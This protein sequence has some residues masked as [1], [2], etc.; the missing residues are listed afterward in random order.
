MEKNLETKM[1]ALEGRQSIGWLDKSFRKFSYLRVCNFMEKYDEQLKDCI[2][3]P[4]NSFARHFNDKGCYQGSNGDL[5]SNDLAS[6]SKFRFIYDNRD[7]LEYSP[8]AIELEEYERSF[9]VKEQFVKDMVVDI[10][11]DVTEFFEDEKNIMLVAVLGITICICACVVC[12]NCCCRPSSLHLE[13]RE[14]DLELEDQR[15]DND[16]NAVESKRRSTNL[17]TQMVQQIRLYLKIELFKVFRLQFNQKISDT[18]SICMNH[19]EGN[20]KAILTPCK[21]IFHQQCFY[22]WANKCINNHMVRVNELR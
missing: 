20:E 4:T 5:Q 21:H 6:D 8:S 16:G 17:K 11:G 10:L 12:K 1:S 14:D 13:E 7:I 15:E 3:C 18:C 9:E 22:E 2:R 19:F